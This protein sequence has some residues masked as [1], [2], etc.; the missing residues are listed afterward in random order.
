V[1]TLSLGNTDL[2]LLV[3]DDL[4]AEQNPEISIDLRREVLAQKVEILLAESEAQEQP[5]LSAAETCLVDL[6]SGIETASPWDYRLRLL[7]MKIRLREGRV[8]EAKEICH[9]A[10]DLPVKVGPESIGDGARLE[11]YYQLGFSLLAILRE[12]EQWEAAVKVCDR[13]A[14]TP[15]QRAAEAA[16]IGETLRTEHFIWEERGSLAPGTLRRP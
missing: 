15:G 8:E 2:A 4:L 5:D 1:A 13:L 9:D 7:R 6:A 10:L 14:R 12:E 16:E 11:G 3:L